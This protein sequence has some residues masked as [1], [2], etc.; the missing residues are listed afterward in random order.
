VNGLAAT[1]TITDADVIAST[2]FGG[3]LADL[4]ESMAAGNTYVNVHTVTYPAGEVRGQI[5]EL[6]V[7]DAFGDDDGNFH[8]DNINAIAAAGITLGTAP[9]QFSPATGVARRQMAAFL[10]RAFNLPSTTTDY[11]TD[12]NGTLLEPEINAVAA[13]GISIGCAANLFCPNQTVTRGQMASFIMRALGLEVAPNGDF[14]DDVAGNTHEA[15]INGLAGLGI[16]TGT[17]ATEYSPAD[18]VRRDQMATFLARTHKLAPRESALF[19][20]TILHNNDGESDLVADG[21]VGGA[22]RFK[23]VV[24]QQKA[25]GHGQTDG[26]LMLSSG[27]NFLAGTAFEA[28]LSDGIF[29]DVLALEAIGYHAIDIGNHDFDFGPDVLADFISAYT[30]PPPYVSANL[31]FSGEAALQALVTAGTIAPSTTVDMDGMTVGIVGATTPNLPFIS[32]PRDV[33]VDS[34]VAGAVQAELDAMEAGGAD[35]LIMISHLQGIDEDIALGPD[36]SGVDVMIAGGGDEL[37][38]NDAS[39]LL[40]GDDVADIFGPYPMSTTNAEA[41][42]VPV[43]TTSGQYGYLGRLVVWFDGAGNVVDAA[44]GPIAINGQAQ[45]ADLLTTV[46]TPVADFQAGLA[47]SVIGTSEVV[48]DGLRDNVRSM[49]TNEGNLIADALLWQAT[50]LAGSFAVNP[51]DVAIQNGGGIRNDDERP[52]PAPGDITELDTFDMLPFGNTLTIVPDIPRAQFKEIL[53][54]A[55]SALNS[56]GSLG[57]GGTGRFAQVAGFSFTWD[58]TGTAQVI[59]PDTGVITTPGTR[60][61]TVTLDA[62]PTPIVVAGA[63]VPGPDVNIAIANF[64]ATGGDQYPF[65]GAPFTNLGVTDQQ[66]LSAYIQALAADGGLEGSITA[67]QYPEGGEGRITGP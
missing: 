4:A 20:L 18:P 19:A 62:G 33:V 47:A 43:V 38:A 17:T 37:L 39:E 59:D 44:G 8:E 58:G 29:Y 34:D 36:L 11:F 65:N 16:T 2:G 27:D 22:A 56:D 48:L 5:A 1:G 45:D 53:E 26:V 7:T 60:I 21:D 28:S 64:L 14:F 55:V 23:A 67:A 61:V 51:P 54:N 49:E 6:T 25:L 9:G 3:T 24:D 13:A 63:V 10:A 52:D 40:P 42:S 15:N 31:D 30:D 46:E 32:S 50:A 41:A 66:S 35:I 12:D 57:S